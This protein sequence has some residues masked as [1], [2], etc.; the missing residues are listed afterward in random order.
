MLFYKITLTLKVVKWAAWGMPWFCFSR[1]SMISPFRSMPPW[2]PPALC[3]GKA[4]LYGLHQ[5]TPGLSGFQKVSAN[6]H[7]VRGGSTR[8][9][10]SPG[11]VLTGE[12]HW[13]SQWL[14]V[15]CTKAHSFCPQPSLGSG[16]LPATPDPR[17]GG[18]RSSQ[19]CKSG[20]CIT[21]VISPNSVK[22]SFP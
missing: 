10:E 11:C 15:P 9:E 21:F 3:L 18:L 13:F 17:S 7:T 12:N 22:W 16:E 19:V 5:C 6:G 2:T 1:T 8:Q 14:G 4:E 20:F